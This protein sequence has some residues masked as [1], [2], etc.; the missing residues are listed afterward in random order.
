MLHLQ[1]KLYMPAP[2][3]SVNSLHEIDI[4][5]Y[6]LHAHHALVLHTTKYTFKNT[7]TNFRTMC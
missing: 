1:N 6:T 5:I 7:K 3:Q 2:S 4:W